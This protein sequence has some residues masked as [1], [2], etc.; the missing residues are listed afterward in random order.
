MKLHNWFEE[1]Y[2]GEQS[3]KARKTRWG[4]RVARKNSGLH[5]ELN[6]TLTSS[7]RNSQNQE[8]RI[9]DR[10]AITLLP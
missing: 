6:F 2:Y 4:Q 3:D 8:K 9:L 10:R 1:Q 7:H 5:R